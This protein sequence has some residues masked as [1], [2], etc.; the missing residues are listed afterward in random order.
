MKDKVK[1]MMMMVVMKTS[2]DYSRSKKKY[3][4]ENERSKQYVN[5]ENI[6]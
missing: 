3:H 4:K 5:H 1:K 6:N 2:K